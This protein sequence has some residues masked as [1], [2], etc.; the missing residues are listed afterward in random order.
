MR[1]LKL[2]FLVLASSSIMAGLKYWLD[3]HKPEKKLARRSP[4]W[5]DVDTTKPMNCLVANDFYVVHLTSYVQTDTASADPKRAEAFRPY[6]RSVPRTG[7]ITFS[8]DLVDKEARKIPVALSVFKVGAS[9][10]RTLVKEQPGAV[11]EAGVAAVTV[12]LPEAGMYAVKLAFAEGKAADEQLD[13]TVAVGM[14]D[15][16]KK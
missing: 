12:N 10:D 14:G 6:C 5:A 7:T 13:V 15:E 8:F 3:P 1:Y 9:G 4:V 2:L 16:K 11:Y